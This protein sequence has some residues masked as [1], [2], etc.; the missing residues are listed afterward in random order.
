MPTKMHTNT[1]RVR[2]FSKTLSCPPACGGIVLVRES[3]IFIEA[4]GAYKNVRARHFQRLFL[5]RTLTVA[6]PLQL[7]LGLFSQQLTQSEVEFRLAIK[8]RSDFGVVK[9]NF[10]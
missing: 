2:Y 6:M 1:Q 10:G 7:E 9:V 8:H 3:F 5:D 4:K